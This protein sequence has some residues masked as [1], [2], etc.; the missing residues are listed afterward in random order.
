M[1]WRKLWL[2]LPPTLTAGI[3]HGITLWFQP[4]DYWAGNYAKADEACPPAEWL[5]KLHPLANEVGLLAWLLLVWGLVLVLP[6]LAG[7]AM[8]LCV[9]IGHT[10][11]ASSW[12]SVKLDEPYWFNIALCIVSGALLALA[13]EAAGVKERRPAALDEGTRDW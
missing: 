3:D 1:K 9:T 12:L 13:L 4:P 7:L 2:C 8:C 6:R 10:W 11:G 5:M